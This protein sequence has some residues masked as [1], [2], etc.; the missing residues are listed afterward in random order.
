M[1]ERIVARVGAAAVV[2]VLGAITLSGC[3]VPPD[4]PSSTSS[5]P[6]D[7]AVF[8]TDEEAL[9]AATEA[10]AAY[11]AMSDLIANEGGANPERIKQVASGA[12]AGREIQSFQTLRDQGIYQEGNSTFD[13]AS[14]QKIE[15]KGDEL[16]VSLYVCSDVAAITIRD[17]NGLDI[18][19]KDRITRVALE[20]LLESSEQSRTLRVSQSEPWSGE[21]FC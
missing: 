18:T 3:T 7:S 16:Q 2:V 5:A 10:Y 14:I 20:V 8:A 17:A 15:E 12:W 1:F 4:P 13:T 6:T 19:P 11:L 9:A 21:S